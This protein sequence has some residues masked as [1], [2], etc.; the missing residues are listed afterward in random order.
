MVLD[1]IP[2]ECRIWYE[3]EVAMLIGKL[4][5]RVVEIIKVQ[6][7]VKFS[8]DKDWVLINLRLGD[9]QS[10][11]VSWH[12]VAPTRFDWVREIHL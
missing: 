1:F 5:E 6:S 9:L 3:K 2:Y 12:P 4:G 8:Q 10:L 11:E 7:T